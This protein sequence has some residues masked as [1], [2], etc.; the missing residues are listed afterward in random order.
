MYRFNNRKSPRYSP[1]EM[2]IALASEMSERA[3]EYLIVQF[4]KLPI[5]I[6]NNALEESET[7]YLT[8]GK[9][10]DL[11]AETSFMQKALESIESQKTKLMKI[12]EMILLVREKRPTFDTESEPNFSQS[13]IELPSRP[14][15][16]ISDILQNVFEPEYY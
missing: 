10:N 1:S 15:E 7:H 14:R 8:F 11:M 6:I 5:E 16:M 9:P 13:L 4:P 3:R 12:M 2:S